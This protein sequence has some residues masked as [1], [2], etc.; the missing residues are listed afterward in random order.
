VLLPT[1][2]SLTPEP[3][4]CDRNF[5]ENAASRPVPLKCLAKRLRR[6][7]L[8]RRIHLFF[9]DTANNSARVSSYK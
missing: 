6:S 8:E 3:D 5:G 2:V 9:I 1:L 7:L 4:K